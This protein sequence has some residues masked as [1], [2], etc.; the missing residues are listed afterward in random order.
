M[1]KA[2]FVADK[3]FEREEDSLQLEENCNFAIHS[4][5]I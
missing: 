2:N 4:L 3:E 5:D 1:F